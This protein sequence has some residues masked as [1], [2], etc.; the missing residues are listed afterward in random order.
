M[1]ET[2]A[3]VPLAD[4]EEQQV[5]EVAADQVTLMDLQPSYQPTWAEIPQK[6][7]RRL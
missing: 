6:L 4:K 1:V 7:D 5:L 3:T 2:V